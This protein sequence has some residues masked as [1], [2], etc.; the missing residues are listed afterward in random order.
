MCPRRW[1]WRLVGLK[2]GPAGPYHDGGWLN[3]SRTSLPIA[4][5]SLE[6][7]AKTW[8]GYTYSADLQCRRWLQIS[9]HWAQSCSKH[10]LLARYGL[11]FGKRQLK[12]GMR[13]QMGAQTWLPDQKPQVNK[14]KTTVLCTKNA[15][16]TTNKLEKSIKLI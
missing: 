11:S 15:C 6:G 13:M 8:F 14:I 1:L 16:R 3:R 9:A 2:V 4:S 10:H 5:Q 7:R 12:S